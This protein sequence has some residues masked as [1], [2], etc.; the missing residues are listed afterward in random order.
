[1]TWVLR[2]RFA[3]V[4]I[5]Y[6]VFLLVWWAWLNVSGNTNTEISY[7]YGAAYPV[8]ALAGGIGGLLLSRKW[9]GWKSIMGRGII[10]LALGLLGQAFGQFTWTFYNLVLQ[11]EVPYPSIADIG[12][13]SII[14]F[15]SLAMVNFARASGVHLS[16]RSYMSKLQAVIVP[17]VMLIF[18][19]VL[20]LRDYEFDFSSPVRILLDFGYPMGEAIIISTAILTLW[21]SRSYLGGLMKPKI[22]YI[23][24]AFFVLYITDYAFLYQA[25]RD[26]YVN[27]GIVDLLYTASFLIMS[28]GLIVVSTLESFRESQSQ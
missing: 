9:G 2:H 24:F 18:S 10:F 3:Q 15:Y 11:V 16:L 13:L 27:G 8:I 1:M 22:R 7:W 23:I 4:L 12:Y 6:F 28:I 5:L 26:T 20:F 17:V 19:Y 21:L 25:S 14:P